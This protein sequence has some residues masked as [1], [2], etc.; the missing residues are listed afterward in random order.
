MHISGKWGALIIATLNN[1]AHPLRF[2][3]LRASIEGI[4]D[5]MLSQTLGL[6]ERDGILVRDEQ[7]HVTYGL[8]PLGHDVAQPLLQLISTVEHNM[9]DILQRNKAYDRSH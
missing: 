2:K 9:A 3:D 5:R 4:S 6:L 7:E 8:S 1:A